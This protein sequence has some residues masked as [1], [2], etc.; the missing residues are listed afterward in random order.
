MR[1]PKPWFRAPECGLQGDAV[2]EETAK[3]A[4]ALKGTEYKLAAY[5]RENDKLFA[6]QQAAEATAAG[7]LLLLTALVGTRPCL[8]AFHGP[9]G[10]MA[11]SDQFL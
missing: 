8:A 2:I 1:S 10:Y 9:I 4:A 11:L 5:K 7:G 3:L 6:G